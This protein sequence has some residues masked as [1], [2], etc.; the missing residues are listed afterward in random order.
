MF[1][2]LSDGVIATGVD[3]VVRFLNPAA[4]ELTGWIPL[5]AIGKAIDEIYALSDIETSE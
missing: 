2:S 4:Q 5:D 1:D 3:G